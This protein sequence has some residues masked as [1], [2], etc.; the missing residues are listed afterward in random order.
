MDGK[1]VEEDLHPGLH[2]LLAVSDGYILQDMNGIRAHIV[3]RLDGKGYDVTKRE[4]HLASSIGCVLTSSCFVKW[5][6]TA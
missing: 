5:V 2:K 3:S 4:C 6:L 1:T